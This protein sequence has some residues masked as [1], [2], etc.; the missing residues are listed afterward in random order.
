MTDGRLETLLFSCH[1]AVQNLGSDGEQGRSR[2]E[3]DRFFLALGIFHD[4]LQRPAFL[5]G[6][7]KPFGMDECHG[8]IR[9]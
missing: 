8:A 9:I 7:F 6:W 4:A 3:T 5:G 2:T 1:F